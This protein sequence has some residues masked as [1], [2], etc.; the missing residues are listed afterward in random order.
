MTGGCGNLSAGSYNLSANSCNYDSNNLS[1]KT[2]MIIINFIQSI[3][4]L[5]NFTPTTDPMSNPVYDGYWY[6]NK[7]VEVANIELSKTFQPRFT[8]PNT[9]NNTG[10]NKKYKYVL[11]GVYFPNN[12]TNSPNANSLNI[13]INPSDIQ[14]SDFV[15]RGFAPALGG[16]IVYLTNGQ[17][18]R[19]KIFRDN[20]FAEW[21]LIES[22]NILNHEI[23]HCL[24]LSHIVQGNS[25]GACC[26]SSTEPNCIDDG[27]PDTAPYSYIVSNGL[28]L[29]PCDWNDSN[30]SQT[31][32]NMMDYNVNQNTLSK[33]QLT[34]I[35]NHITASKL[36]LLKC[37]LPAPTLNINNLNNKNQTYI[38]QKINLLQPINTQAL[39]VTA[40]KSIW[41]EAQEI[42]FQAGFEVQLGGMLNTSL[43]P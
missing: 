18:H 34:H 12:T 4:P 24:G 31:S 43:C 37:N 6:A 20:N 38:S 39:V 36:P 2:I 11:S 40:E 3:P 42:T 15:Q 1:E 21:I 28:S 7:L 35:H 22:S 32:N 30:N 14:N 19:Y 10:L 41:V 26:S 8:Y 13:Y 29:N 5:I 23:G 16:N 17:V 9:G 27:M 33:C 25:L